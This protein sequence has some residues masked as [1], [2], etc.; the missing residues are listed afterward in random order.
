M[1]NLLTLIVAFF[2]LLFKETVKLFYPARCKNIQG[3]IALVTGAGRGL[4]K[5][6]AHVLAEKGCEIVAV[7]IN[8]AGVE[9]TAEE[10]T[11]FGGKAIAFKCDIS[12]SDEVVELQRQ[13]EATVGPVD[14]LVNNAGIIYM[15]SFDQN[16][17][18]DIERVVSVNVT[19]LI[20]VSSK[21]EKFAQN[22]FAKSLISR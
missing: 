6:I 14:I 4:G 10:I 7:D 2:C 17:L 9:A 19:G 13:V 16:T 3:Q 5:E 12:K 8:L 22:C 21:F 15:Q 11:E 1:E 18:P 20:N